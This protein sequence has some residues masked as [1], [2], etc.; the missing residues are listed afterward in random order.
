MSRETYSLTLFKSQ[1]DNRT[2]KTMEFK[3]WDDF[4][5][6]L[7]QLSY[8]PIATK[9]D[10]PLISP[11][12]YIPDTTRANK[13]VTGWGKWACVDVDDYTGDINDIIER[14]DSYNT[15]IYSTASSTAEQIKFR[16]VFDLDVRVQAG[17]VKALWYAINSYLEDLGDAQTKDSSRMYYVP[18]DYAGAYSFFYRTHGNPLR[19]HDLMKAHPYIVSSGNSFMDNLPDEVRK[20]VL[21]H[22]ASKMDKKDITW[23]GYLDCPFVS[24][25]MVSNYKSI[26]GTGWYT[27]LYKIMIAIACNAVK[28]QYPITAQEIASLCRQLDN[29]TGSWYSNRPIETEAER[30]ISYAYLTVYE[31]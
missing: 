31:E 24:R 27:N 19:V 28:N 1:F 11:A 29:D 21:E 3:S 15:V 10:A 8:K 13:N 22:R 30:A 17:E 14:F 16:I 12:S 23:S 26:A 2:D 5:N 4:V 6:L 20:Q 9:R 25:N 18:A 7:E